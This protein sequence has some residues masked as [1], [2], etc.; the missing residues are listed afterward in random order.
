MKYRQRTQGRKKTATVRFGDIA[1]R[2]C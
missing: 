2:W 1:K